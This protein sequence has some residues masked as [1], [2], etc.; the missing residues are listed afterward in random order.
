MDTMRGLVLL[1]FL[2][3]TSSFLCFGQTWETKN[4]NVDIIHSDS[5][6]IRKL[7]RSY[8][9]SP[10]SILQFFNEDIPKED[11]LGYGYTSLNYVQEKGSITFL[12]QAIY[13]KN[14]LVSYQLKMHLFIGKELNKRY[15]AFCSPLFEFRH[16]AISE[17]LYYNYHGMIKPLNANHATLKDKKLQ[18]LI[19]PFSGVYYGYYER[20][21]YITKVLDNRMNF[22]A[23][24]DKLTPDVIYELLYSKNPATRLTAAEYFYK[25]PDLFNN[26]KTKFEDRI[27]S[28]YNELPIVATMIDGNYTNQYAKDLVET[29]TN[30]KL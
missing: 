8:H 28:I 9:K 19:T 25:N 24:K 3:F 22:N 27:S 17:P 29:F 16:E 18:Y 10:M 1:P 15:R 4:N 6:F 21:G 13:F 11:N 12:C 30:S 23:V 14:K 7:I 26:D 5:L 20:F 2:L